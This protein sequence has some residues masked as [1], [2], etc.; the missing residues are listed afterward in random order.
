M[1]ENVQSWI[2]QPFSSNMSLWGWALF[3]VVLIT[4]VYLWNDV[5]SIIVEGGKEL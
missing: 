5:L 2:A 3:I 1:L 4:I